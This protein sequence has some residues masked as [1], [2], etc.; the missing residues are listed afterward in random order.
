MSSGTTNEANINFLKGFDT[1]STRLKKE[2]A[3]RL[4]NG[5]ECLNFGVSFLDE[6]LGGIY[7]NDLI[8]VGAKTGF[9]KS[10]LASL[11]ATENVKKGKRVHFLALEAEEFEIERR[12]KYQF[13]ADKFF[14]LQSKP[15][16]RLN[17]MDWYYGKLDEHLKYIEEEV[18]EE[19][20]ELSNLNVYYRTGAFD[21]NEFER[22]ALGIKN[23]TDL[24]I[25]DHLHYFDYDDQ[26]ENKAIKQIVKTI[27]DCALISG[28]PV[29]LIAHVRKTDKRAKQL[30]PD[31]EDFHGS[32]DI[33]KIAT[34]AIT[35]APCYDESASAHRK[36]YF[37]A[38]K[39]RVDG[40]RTSM[41]GLSAFNVNNHKYEKQY[42][43]GKVSADGTD[44]KPFDYNE[45]PFWALNAIAGR[46]N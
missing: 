31:I 43:L 19:L 3:I 4:E 45:M 6:C 35:L 46:G 11:I 26:N 33:G 28:K 9:G 44:F 30:I 14:K 7:K 10:Q 12:I 24:I 13:I 41:T 29:I 36:T 2:R 38:L 5:K 18:E 34:K 32:S 23:E 22:I 40:S 20:H 17:Y 21:V 27:R 25:I 15:P 16:I 1:F 39:C 8:L 42:Y 37:Q